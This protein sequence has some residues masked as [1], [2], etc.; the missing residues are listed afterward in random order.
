MNQYT[1]Q[2]LCVYKLERRLPVC[3]YFHVVFTIQTEPRATRFNTNF[4]GLDYLKWLSII[5]QT[6]FKTLYCCT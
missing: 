1:R 2:L 4:P 5:G 3:Q 6:G